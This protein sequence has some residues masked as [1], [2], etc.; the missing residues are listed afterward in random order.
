MIVCML[1]LGINEMKIITIDYMARK[2]EHPSI[3]NAVAYVITPDSYSW[4]GALERLE[5]RQNLV[6]RLIT[7]MLE[8]Q[9]LDTKTLIY[10]LGDKVVSVEV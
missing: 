9:K 4:S 2:I 1:M 6:I 10:I 3:E 5:E 7:R 8:T